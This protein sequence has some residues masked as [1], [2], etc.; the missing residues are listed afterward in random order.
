MTPERWRQLEAVFQQ[1]LDLPEKQRAAYLHRECPADLRA[2]VDAML[3]A[4]T[5]T[6]TRLTGAERD[7]L[8][9]GE[10]KLRDEQEERW[11]A[12]HLLR[13]VIEETD[14]PALRRNAAIG[15]ATAVG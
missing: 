3:T 10:R 7:R 4:D 2:E 1:A 9:A 15:P 5:G 12:Y 14:S 11:R 13:E 8:T 6:D